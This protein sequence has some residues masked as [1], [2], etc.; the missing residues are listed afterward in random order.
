MKKLARA[1]EGLPLDQGLCAEQAKV[2]A[3]VQGPDPQEGTVGF[4]E[5]RALRFSG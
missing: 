4:L 1:S 5:K 3:I 2:V